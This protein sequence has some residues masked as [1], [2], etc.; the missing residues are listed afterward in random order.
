MAETTT[1]PAEAG[2][3]TAPGPTAA[4]APGRGRRGWVAG[5]VRGCAGTLRGWFRRPGRLAAVTG[6][7]LL[8]ALGS[9]LGG[10]EV[11]A[12]VHFRAA[13]AALA[14]YHDADAIRH[15]EACL[16]VWPRDP[17]TLLLA[18]RAA[19]RL[20]AFDRAQGFLDRY[21]A[22][23]GPEDD[24]V[25]ERALLCAARGDVDDVAK[26]CHTRVEQDDPASPLILEALAAGYTRD[27]RTAEAER[28]VKTWLERQPDN[29]RALYFQGVMR[30]ARAARLEAVASFK[31]VLELDPQQDEARLHLAR[32]LVDMAQPAEVLPHLEYLRRR[33]PG[34]LLIQ[35]DLARCLDQLGRQAEA[36]QVLD[37]VLARS[38]DL[39]PALAE[40]GRLALR[41]DRPAEAE[42]YLFHAARVEPADYEIHYHLYL[43]L[44]QNGKADEARAEQARLKHIEE[45]LAHIQDIVSVQMQRQ[46]HNP[47][48]HYEVG[49]ISLR[50]GAVQEA[51]RWFASALREDPYHAPTHRALAEYYDRMGEPGRASRHRDLW[52]QA[53]ARRP[54][55][56]RGEA[57]A[58]RR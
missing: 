18:A 54:E 31:R 1:T 12:M 42:G 19:R 56:G 32:L 53:T 46:P 28:A 41:A 11:W 6:L 16:A 44:K 7:G 24:L 47:D 25:L 26:F 37:E 34:N 58:P 45:D 9:V 30:E 20:E 23:A 40:R 50:A 15:L 22:A 2:S 27:F 29:P 48:L 51:L 38:P 8:I 57:P 5:A 3:A 17:D 49:M 52:R 43:A 4:A 35:V 39:A 14:R 13:R 21:H 33:Q 55:S 36:E 10:V